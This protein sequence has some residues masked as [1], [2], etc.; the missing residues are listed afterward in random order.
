MFFLLFVEHQTLKN[1]EKQGSASNISKLLPGQASTTH[2]K[3]GLSGAGNSTWPRC[4][5]GGCA[6]GWDWPG[7]M[8]WVNWVLRFYLECAEQH[9]G[10]SVDVANVEIIFSQ[11]GDIW[12]IT[13]SPQSTIICTF[14]H[15]VNPFHT[16]VCASR[17]VIC[18]ACADGAMAVLQPGAQ[19]FV[20]GTCFR[21]IE[22][23]DQHRKAKTISKFIKINQ[24]YESSTFKKFQTGIVE[25]A[26]LCLLVL[27]L[28]TL[29]LSHRPGAQEMGQNFNQFLGNVRHC[30]AVS[31]Y[32]TQLRDCEMLGQLESL[33]GL[34]MKWTTWN[35]AS[36][37]VWI[38]NDNPWYSNQNKC[39]LESRMSLGVKTTPWTL[40][41]H[42]PSWSGSRS[43]QSNSKK[44]LDQRT[45]LPLPRPCLV[46]Y[47]GFNIP[48]DDVTLA[49]CRSSPPKVQAL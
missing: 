37:R 25:F 36:S 42:S 33:G 3:N 19:G 43:W 20:G 22:W 27:V 14:P 44:V 32:I 45:Q 7:R 21:V 5:F 28:W 2:H 16:M 4:T 34:E 35:Q 26:L 12:Y 41:F 18:M 13:I 49:F 9:F 8:I 38:I 46:Y 11:A 48:F 17:M 10:P 30:A 39:N 6:K 31:S 1:I 23:T 15:F 40:S 29:L 24:D 47:A